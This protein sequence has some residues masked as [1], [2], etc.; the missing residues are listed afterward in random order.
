MEDDV[1]GAGQGRQ[2]AGLVTGMTGNWGH[3]P[4]GVTDVSEPLPLS[5]LPG[6]WG[7][8]PGFL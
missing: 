2:E 1:Q 3:V 5:V 8:P 6:C 4:T 7:P